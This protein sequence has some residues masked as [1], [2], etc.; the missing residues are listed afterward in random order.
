MLLPVVSNS[1]VELGMLDLQTTVTSLLLAIS[2]L[3]TLQRSRA[4]RVEEWLVD[5]EQVVSRVALL[6]AETAE[7]A[8]DVQVRHMPGLKLHLPEHVARV[9]DLFE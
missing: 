9:L 1:P 6:S 8:H 4:A 3:R 7:D 5:L 2:L